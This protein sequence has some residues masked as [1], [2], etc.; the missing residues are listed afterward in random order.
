MDCKIFLVRG[1]PAVERLCRMVM[2]II[3]ERKKKIK[4]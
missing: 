4:K 2:L 3:H 1:A